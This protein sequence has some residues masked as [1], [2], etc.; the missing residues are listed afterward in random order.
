MTVTERAERSPTPDPLGMT[1]AAPAVRHREPRSMQRVLT[2]VVILYLG[3]VLIAPIAALLLA[4]VRLGIPSLLEAVTSD[5]A[6][7][8]LNVSL[9]LAA[10]ALLFNGVFGIATAL[11]LVRD[12]Y[13]LARPIGALLDISLAVSPVMAGLA[14]LLL[15]GRGGW[16]DG[17]SIFGFRVP[18]AFPA[19]VLATLFVTLPYVAAECGH[20]LQEVGTEEEAAAS[21]LGASAWRTF[22]SVTL[23]NVKGGLIVG[24]ILTVTRAL[25]EFGAVLVIG[26]AIAGKTE[27]ATTYIYAATEERQ[28]AGA[29]GMAILL[30]SVSLVSLAIVALFQRTRGSK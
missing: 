14:M 12:R 4:A 30:A 21:T 26:G 19:L 2:G 16:L 5:Y 18:F 1:R 24:G 6:L 7:S 17:F 10:F 13:F 15:F 20:M 23:P 29:V 25:G 8:S 28:H 9:A 11:V 3:V 27:T 22:R